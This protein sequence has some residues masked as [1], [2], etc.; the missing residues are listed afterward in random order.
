MEI[1]KAADN[2]LSQMQDVIGQVN[3]SDFRKPVDILGDSTLGQHVRHTLEFFIRLME[4]YKSGVVNYDNRSHDLQI[5][6]DK[7]LTM[8]LLGRIKDFILADPK[9]EAK[10]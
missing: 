8:D 1:K 2:V 5:E 6:N 3:D 10:S 4:G 7:D 9:V